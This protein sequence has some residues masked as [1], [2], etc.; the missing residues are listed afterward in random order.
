MESSH[1]KDLKLSHHSCMQNR[2][3]EKEQLTTVGQVG[4]QAGRQAGR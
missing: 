1:I 2:F 4:G 3:P